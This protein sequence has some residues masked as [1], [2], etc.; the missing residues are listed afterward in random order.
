MNIKIWYYI[1]PYKLQFA[2]IF[3]YLTI[4]SSSILS[5][6]YII[7]KFLDHQFASDELHN[8]NTALL[9]L[10]IFSVI[11]AVTT[12]MRASNTNYICEQSIKRI[13]Y[14]ALNNLLKL[15]P[16]EIANL[17]LSNIQLRLTE[18]TEIIKD[19]MRFILSTGARNIIMLL[20]SL[21]LL[22]F[23]SV[24]L[25]II[26]IIIIPAFILPII[27]VVKKLQKKSLSAQAYNNEFNQN[28]LHKFS[29]LN[30]VQVFNQEQY[31]LDYFSKLLE[32]ISHINILRSKQRSMMVAIIIGVTFILISLM[33]WLGGNDVI[34]NRLT[35]GEL[36]SFIY[37]A[38]VAAASFG[39]ITETFS[40]LNKASD[41][42]E[43]IADLIH[44]KSNIIEHDIP[45]N[46]DYT[47]ENIIEFNNIKFQHNSEAKNILLDFSLKIKK[48]EK[49]AI[50][51]PSGCGKSTLFHLLLRFYEPNEGDI[52]LYG[53]DIKNIT[54]NTLREHISLVSQDVYLFAS[55]IYDNILYSK[56]NASEQEITDALRVSGYDDIDRAKTNYVENMGS[57]LSGGEK[58][59]IAI[60][61]AFLKN[62]DILLLDEA[63]SAM[64]SESE[65]AI[66]N[67]MKHLP[68]DK[69]CITIAHR[70]STVK[71]MDRI[72][73]IN[74]DGIEQIGTIEELQ[75]S[76]PT[77]QKYLSMQTF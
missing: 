46:L 65:F 66:Q 44:I 54:K 42:M 3:C 52:S 45:I 36:S 71:Y 17:K 47:R 40:D 21:V 35:I 37:Y 22:F 24:K 76:S 14:D 43:R 20:G 34:G 25:T 11:L 19:I 8:L 7:R 12:Y 67:A 55:S 5:M 41:A 23:S 13:K 59:K 61:R 51:G 1:K 32:K 31:E 64:D 49:I 63:T 9:Y 26:T 70:L 69:T 53:T 50:I 56:T 6:G 75:K 58:Q 28:F 38:I 73:V 68:N 39:A 16:F 72:I 48:G 62:S 15:S 60:A 10:V 4:S 74:F 2:K 18:D 77:F 27:M 29:A 33:L 30:I 57:N